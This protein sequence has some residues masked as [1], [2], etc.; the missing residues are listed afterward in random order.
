MARAE[1]VR[2]VDAD[3]VHTRLDIGWGVILLPRLGDEPNFGTLRVVQFD[4]SR[5]D[6]PES[7][8][9][10]GR[11]ATKFVNSLVK[12]GDRLAVVS[13]GVATDGRRTLASIQ[14]ANG[15]DW[16]KTCID[17]GFVK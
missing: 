1:V 12:P 5:W 11:A 4:G 3:T 16:A 6:A 17:A 2:V 14:L 7:T 10:L 15:A 8:T 9:V 13:Y